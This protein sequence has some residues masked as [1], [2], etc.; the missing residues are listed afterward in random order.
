MLSVW[1]TRFPNRFSEYGSCYRNQV[2]NFLRDSAHY[3]THMTSV[4]PIN[5]PVSCMKFDLEIS[6]DEDYVSLLCTLCFWQ[7]NS[8]S[9]ELQTL[10]LS[11][12]LPETEPEI[13][14]FVMEESPVLKLWLQLKGLPEQKRLPFA[15]KH[16]DI[17][18]VQYLHQHGGCL[19]TAKCSAYAI[20]HGHI[21]CLMYALENGCPLPGNACELAARY[22]QVDC[23][24][25]LRQQGV[26]QGTNICTEAV[27]GSILQ[28]LPEFTLTKDILH[29]VL[30]QNPIRSVK[31]FV[32]AVK[33]GHMK[34]VRFLVHQHY[35]YNLAV[36]MAAVENGQLE[37]LQYLHVNGCNCD[38]ATVYH[39]CEKFVALSPHV[40][41]H[42]CFATC[43]HECIAQNG[44]YNWLRVEAIVI[45]SLTTNPTASAALREMFG[46]A[47]LAVRWK[48]STFRRNFNGVAT[49]ALFHVLLGMVV[50]KTGKG[51]VSVR[52]VDG[53]IGVA[54][55][56]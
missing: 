44:P 33:R 14:S 48:E 42:A 25:Y 40:P 18:A 53:Q 52:C 15:M 56:V 12:A 43:L 31:A 41:E 1:G 38:Q 36:Y 4:L 46:H 55:E 5:A 39:L 23:Y 37:C 27:R 11:R 3:R 28:N 47:P 24:W 7:V 22:G 13:I 54:V 21:Q 2:P 29:C 10:I 16:G 19:W 8:L 50:Y 34:I 17:A 30:E 49:L 51:C 20:K 6:S 26:S 32:E 9:Q 45:S 35:P